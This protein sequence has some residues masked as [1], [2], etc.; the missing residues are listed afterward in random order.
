MTIATKANEMQKIDDGFMIKNHDEIKNNDEFIIHFESFINDFNKFE[1]DNDYNSKI[2]IDKL[3]NVFKGLN[4]HDININEINKLMKLINKFDDDHDYEK[5]LKLKRGT[6]DHLNYELNGYD[7]E[8]YIFKIYVIIMKMTL[9]KGLY[10]D[11]KGLAAY[12]ADEDIEKNLKDNFVDCLD[13][14]IND[15]FN[16]INDIYNEAHETLLTIGKYDE[17]IRF[18][19]RREAHNLKHMAENLKYD[20]YDIDILDDYV[21]MM[22]D[23]YEI[24]HLSSFCNGEKLVEFNKEYLYGL[25][26]LNIMID[27][28]IEGFNDPL[29]YV[30]ELANAADEWLEE[31]E[32]INEF[33]ENDDDD[34][35]Y[36][37]EICNLINYIKYDL[38]ND[39]KTALENG[40]DR[41]QINKKL[42]LNYIRNKLL[43]AIDGSDYYKEFDE[44]FENVVSGRL[45]TIFN[46]IDY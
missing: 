25:N 6:L 43:E 11:L 26:N 7:D 30:D 16:I 5:R 45:S 1:A 34:N 44:L 27:N 17:R 41:D 12:A 19:K 8:I 14:M 13:F 32:T 4:Y 2:I 28:Y 3:V 22:K 24:Y 42:D 9:I 40:F 20:D 23:L 10:D 33:D 36:Y 29:Y 39:Y 18:E 15:K 21:S 37:C 35:N 31:V 46:L 38:Y